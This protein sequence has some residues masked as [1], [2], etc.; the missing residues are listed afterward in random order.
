[1]LG[2]TLLVLFVLF[3]FGGENVGWSGRPTR[4]PE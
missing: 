4:P 1:M 2:I 3:V